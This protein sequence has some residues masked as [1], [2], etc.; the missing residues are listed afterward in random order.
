MFGT[1]HHNRAYRQCRRRARFR[2]CE[3][4]FLPSWVAPST[5]SY[6]VPA[7]PRIRGAATG[8]V[9]RQ[10]GASQATQFC[11]HVESLTRPEAKH[12]SSLL[13]QPETHAWL[14]VVSPL[15]RS[16]FTFIAI[17]SIHIRTSPSRPAPS[18]RRPPAGPGEPPRTEAG[19]CSRDTLRQQAT[20]ATREP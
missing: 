13:L 2:R 4:R 1:P 17:L 14:Q 11:Q 8:Y 18:R 3:D 16:V 9:E 19:G 6:I 15:R 5:R 10:Q 7:A 20:P 12:A